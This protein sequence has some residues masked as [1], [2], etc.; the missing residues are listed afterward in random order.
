MNLGRIKDERHLVAILCLAVTPVK[1]M[2][3]NYW[4]AAWVLLASMRTRIPLDFS[5]HHWFF[6]F[7]S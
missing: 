1:V 7:G 2:C 6:N 3:C 5:V 4:E